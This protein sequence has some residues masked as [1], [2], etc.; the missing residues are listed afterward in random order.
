MDKIVDEL[1]PKIQ[2]CGQ[3]L[4]VTLRMCFALK[5]D[6]S[7]YGACADEAIKTFH[8]CGKRGNFESPSNT[9]TRAPRVI[10]PL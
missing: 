10:D 5:S 4:R 3:Q 8:S 6:L 2:H 9:S 1:P 7:S